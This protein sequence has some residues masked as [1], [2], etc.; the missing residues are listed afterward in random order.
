MRKILKIIFVFI[1]GITISYCGTGTDN[2][3]WADASPKGDPQGVGSSGEASDTL[4]ALD[5]DALISEYNNYANVTDLGIIER[6]DSLES[7]FREAFSACT[8]TKIFI[9]TTTDNGRV[10]SLVVVTTDCEIYVHTVGS[11]ANEFYGD[12]TATCSSLEEN[13]ELEY[14][15]DIN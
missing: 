12:E 10:A 6:S 9:D 13:E 7:S 2:P 15:C 14:A 3:T 8:P 11:D 1:L 5:F 4:T